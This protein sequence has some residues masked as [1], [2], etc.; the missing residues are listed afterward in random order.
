MELRS[1]IQKVI[2]CYGSEENMI[3]VYDE[4]FV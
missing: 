1:H 4:A 3:A 2:I